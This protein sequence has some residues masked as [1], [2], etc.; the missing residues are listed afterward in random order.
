MP[1]ITIMVGLA[2]M[3]SF[4]TVTP[5]IMV[6]CPIFM[7]LMKDFG[8]SQTW[9]GV[10]LVMNMELSFISPP[11]GYNLFYM[12]A[13]TPDIDPTITVGDIYLSVL[14]FCGCV[15]VGIIIVCLVPQLATWLPKLIFGGVM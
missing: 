15:I 1:V 11:F 5:M 6:G 8:F 13:V 4:M 7:P 14:P 2:I 12:R 3:G 9:F 10:L